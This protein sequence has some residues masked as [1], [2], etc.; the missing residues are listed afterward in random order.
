[1]HHFLGDIH[2]HFEDSKRRLGTDGVA[3]KLK[4]MV[5]TANVRVVTIR[6]LL[7]DRIGIKLEGVDEAALGS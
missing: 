2:F 4:V 6:C 7:D 5:D 1:M 3:P